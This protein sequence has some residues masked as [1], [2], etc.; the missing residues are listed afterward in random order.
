MRNEKNGRRGRETEPTSTMVVLIRLLY[1]SLSGFPSCWKL[2][3]G[4]VQE[5]GNRMASIQESFMWD[6][7]DRSGMLSLSGQSSTLVIGH[8]RQLKSAVRHTAHHPADP[9]RHPC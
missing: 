9:D 4:L 2:F 3:G 7:A 6:G 5:E 1:A 8:H